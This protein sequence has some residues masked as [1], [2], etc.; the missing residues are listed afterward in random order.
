MKTNLTSFLLF[1]CL[2]TAILSCKKPDVLDKQTSKNL[3]TTTTTP[4]R[5]RDSVFANVDSFPNF[6]YR[7]VQNY[8]R[9]EDLK[10]DVYMPSG[11][12]ASKRACIVFIHGGGWFRGPENGLGSRKGE[13]R[14]CI[15]YA[16]RGYTVISPSYRLGKD[17]KPRQSS[18]DSSFKVY[19]GVYRAAQDVRAMLRFL[20]KNSTAGKIDTNKIFIGGGSAG[21]GNAINTAYLDQLEIGNGFTANWG[22]LDGNGVYDYPGYSLKVKGVL[23]IAGAIFDKNYIDAGDPP[24]ISFYGSEDGY[25]KDS[26]TIPG[27][28]TPI[29]RFDNGKKIH[30]RFS[31]LGIITPPIVLFQGQGHAN[32]DPTAFTTILNATCAW[33]YNLLQP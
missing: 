31:Q 20:K 6:F 1:I 5:Y 3:I 8:D 9:V 18:S 28:M 33:M 11:D 21:A 2:A 26:L 25:Y 22:K 23:N 30:Q 24:M 17:F 29:F 16:K 12:T 14:F 10:F 7:T 27:P 32:N 19:E 15:A 13:R 4:V